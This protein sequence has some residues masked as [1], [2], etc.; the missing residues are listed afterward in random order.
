[1]VCELALEVVGGWCPRN[2]EVC[3]DGMVVMVVVV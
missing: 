2:G 1:M 3:G